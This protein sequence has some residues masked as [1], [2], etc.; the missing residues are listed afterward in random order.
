MSAEHAIFRRAHVEV[1]DGIAFP[2]RLQVHDLQSLE[3]FLLAFEVGVE[4]G[5][6]QRLAEPS[7]YLRCCMAF[8]V[9]YFAKIHI[10]L[11]PCKFFR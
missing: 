4:R 8:V 11:R 9:F 3:E 7:G 1:D 10:L 5:G 2:F 6:E